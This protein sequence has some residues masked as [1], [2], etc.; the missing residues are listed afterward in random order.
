[1]GTTGSVTKAG[2]G[3]LTLTGDNSYTG[4]T[5]VANGTLAIGGTGDINQTSGVTISSAGTF[6]YNSSVAYSGGA[7]SNNGGVIAGSGTISSSVALDSLNDKLAPGNS[8]GIQN[9]GVSQTWNAFT[10]LWETN[11]FTGITAGTDFDKIT[12]TGSLTLDLTGSYAV[13]L[14]SL[15]ALNAAG[16]VANFSETDRQWAILTASGGI[17]NIDLA[18]WTLNAAGFSSSPTRTGNFTLS[19]DANNIYLNYAVVPEPS[20]TLLVALGTLGLAARRR[21]SV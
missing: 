13:D 15:T 11:N 21:R 1:M 10:Y 8:P 19:S 5:A 4:S 9:Y 18:D 20:G 12:V 2:T 17:S 14:L 3:T 6:R 16:N 7:I